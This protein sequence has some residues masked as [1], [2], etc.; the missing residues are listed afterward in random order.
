MTNPNL[1]APPSGLKTMRNVQ[2]A[3]VLGEWL[4]DVAR[5][6]GES[7]LDFA[8]TIGW[9]GTKEQRALMPEAHITSARN[10]AIQRA[11]WGE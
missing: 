7:A 9:P 10:E 6:R 3:S 2:A 11:S 5:L 1:P 8:L 4:M